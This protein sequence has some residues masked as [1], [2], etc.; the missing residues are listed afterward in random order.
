MCA[1]LSLF[2]VAVVLQAPDGAKVYA[3][4][5][6][7]C[8]DTQA[9]PRIPAVSVLRQ[10]SVDEIFTALTSG[11]MR[12]QGSDLTEAE[13]RAVAAF[14]GRSTAA[15]GAPANDQASNACASTPAFDPTKGAS[16]TGWSPDLANTRFQ[17][18][19][20]LTG[21]QVSKLTLKWAF[22]F[23]NT[24]TA[25]ALPT[26]AGG[27]VFVGSQS[28]AVYALDAATGCTIWT[29][30]AKGP[31]RSGIVIALRTSATAARTCTPSTRPPARNSGRAAWRITRARTSPARRPCIRIGSTSL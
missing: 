5:C 14:L 8:H 30:R 18:R 1:M 24:T 13:R 26:V 4:Q 28:G 7:M 20:G 6:A 2:L 27:R 31:V 9:D 25:R 19:P 23:P 17:P 15:S 11:R 21:D 3:E 22:G 12:E 16:W 29:Y 10:K